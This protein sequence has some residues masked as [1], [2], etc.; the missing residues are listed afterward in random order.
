MK[1][2]DRGIRHL[3]SKDKRYI[4]WK[5]GGNGFG[6]RISPQGRKTFITIYNFGGKSRMLSHGVYP[7]MSL[8]EA[9]R[10]HA[11]A[12]EKIDN[13]IDPGREIVHAR[14]APTVEDLA[15]EYMEKWA[16]PRKRTWREDQR[17]LGKDVLPSWGNRKARDITRRDVIV[18]LDRI[19][20]RGSPIAANRTLAVIRRMFNFAVSQDILGTT[21][22]TLIKAP[23]PENR[24]D[25]VLSLDEVKTFW[26]ALDELTP[27]MRG[28]FKLQLLTAQ[29]PGEVVKAEWGEIQGDWWIIPKHKAK[30]TLSH[31]VPLSPHVMG[32]LNEIKANSG[33]SRWLFPSP[34]GDKPIHPDSLPRVISR[35]RDIFAIEHFTPHDL[36]RTAAS[37][38]T[39]MGISRLVVSK[40]LNHAESGITAV[41]DRHSY[42]AEK[43]QALDGW[44]RKIESIVAGSTDN[45][46]DLNAMR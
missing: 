9:T 13:G 34:Q 33:E 30:N 39:S 25:R 32:V 24:R 2:T 35:N 31:R 43:R 19:V 41:Y 18:L 44:G 10:A 38:M 21:P 45:V 29:R 7:Q 4:E 27:L 11:Q 17:I 23:S 40:I 12:L 6:L 16:K 1:F 28:V 22:V 5:D 37:H 15:N 26:L 3:K 46:V 14:R 8:A 42:D 20:S 36:R